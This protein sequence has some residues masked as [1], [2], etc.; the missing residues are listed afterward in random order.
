M[1]K[2]TETTE[3]APIRETA[4]QNQ[5]L[6]GIMVQAGA[7]QRVALDLCSAVKAATT[8]EVQIP[9][10]HYPFAI[11]ADDIAPLLGKWIAELNTRANNS[12]IVPP[13]I[14]GASER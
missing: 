14:V 4:K 11:P 10:E 13:E 7:F 9:I 12:T 8:L 5:A 3:A 1:A 6:Q 2:Q